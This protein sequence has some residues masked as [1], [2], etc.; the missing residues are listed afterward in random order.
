M[1]CSRTDSGSLPASSELGLLGRVAGLA[2][3]ESLAEWTLPSDTV[4]NENGYDENPEP[5]AVALFHCPPEV[6][7]VFAGVLGHTPDLRGP[8]GGH[9]KA[10]A[11][12]GA[13]PYPIA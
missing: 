10:D 9:I 4:E 6:P 2:C 7:P 3:V 1:S 13:P 11:I 8:A 5:D 12:V